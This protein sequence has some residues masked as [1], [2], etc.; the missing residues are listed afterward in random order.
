MAA[1]KKSLKPNAVCKRDGKWDN[2]D[3]T[4]LVPGDL[5]MLGSGA[6][7]PADCRVNGG[8]IEVDQAALTGE[9]LPVAMTFG[10][11]P[12]MG[13][14]VTRGEVEATVEFTGKNTFFG[15]TAAMIQSVE[16]MSHFQ[17]VLLRI[18]M[19]LL[20]VS[21]VLCGICLIYLLVEGE[22]GRSAIGWVVVL[23][24]ASIPLA[25]EV[26]TTTT[27]AIGSRELAA[28]NAIVARLAA[29]EEL[30][31]MDMLC[32]DKTGT[33]TLNKMV[34]QEDT[35]VYAAG[36]NQYELLR[37]AALAAKWHEPP[38]DALDTLVLVAADL[39]SLDEFEQTDYMPFDPV[40]KRTEG[41]L[42]RKSDGTMFKVTK[43]APHIILK[44]THD[45]KVAH[46][47]HETVNALAERGIRALAV[48]RTLPG[49][50]EKWEML[51]V[52]TFLD[53]P[54]PDTKA[55]LHKAI[56]YG[57]LVKM[58]TGDHVAIAKECAR[59]LGIG[60]NILDA[61]GL[62][63]LDADGKAPKNLHEYAGLI[64]SADGFAQARA[65]A[66]RLTSTLLCFRRTR[67]AR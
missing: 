9:S 17:K 28:R 66:I 4:L 42:K 39:P 22:P 46:Q 27:M 49:S 60:T 19:F 64:Q 56:E 16:E 59:Q 5:V 1:L 58:I 30:A 14:T 40:M 20:V 2:I 6:A 54:R 29:I 31:G 37:M 15:K 47:V 32:S 25:I 34:I 13:S 61:Q 63:S 35:P 62:P 26:V 41:T 7:V 67:I 50:L 43:G 44:L 12:K 52:L 11:Q 48:A 24:V 8:R 33:L 21:F 3:A 38:K 18:M 51:G 23:L 65:R 10:S 36:M 53:P 57:I 45:D 55:V